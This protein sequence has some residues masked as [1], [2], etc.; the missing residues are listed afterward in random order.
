MVRLI[1]KQKINA[2]DL[3]VRGEEVAPQ[4]S[5]F[6]PHPPQLRHPPLR[7]FLLFLAEVISGG[8]LSFGVLGY[9]VPLKKTSNMN[10]QGLFYFSGVPVKDS[11]QNENSK[12]AAGLGASYFSLFCFRGALNKHWNYAKILAYQ[13]HVLPPILFSSRINAIA[14][15]TLLCEGRLC[16]QKAVPTPPQLRPPSRNRIFGLFFSFPGCAEEC[17][18]NIGF[19]LA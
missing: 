8:K 1:R 15:K 17:I 5:S 9:W 10:L 2:L 11:P 6:R 18:E 4:D 7:I 16:L 14:G 3:K 19:F 13:L 12:M